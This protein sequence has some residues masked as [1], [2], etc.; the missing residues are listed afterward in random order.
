MIKRKRL[1]DRQLIS[2][3]SRRGLL[4]LPKGK[5]V[6]IV[7]GGCE[8]KIRANAEPIDIPQLDSGSTMLVEGSPAFSFTAPADTP[9]STG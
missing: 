1:T 9:S 6:L 8:V 4:V 3:A 5:R 7:P 2:M